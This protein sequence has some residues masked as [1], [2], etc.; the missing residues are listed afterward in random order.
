M[1]SR[2]EYSFENH[3]RKILI[4]DNRQGL[5]F[6]A[7]IDRVMNSQEVESW[8]KEVFDR[9]KFIR[10]QKENADAQLDMSEE[11]FVVHA[12]MDKEAVEWLNKQGMLRKMDEVEE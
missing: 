12:M 1:S 9:Y 5:K 10:A 2:I 8:L 4:V 7:E 11:G 6:S 3:N